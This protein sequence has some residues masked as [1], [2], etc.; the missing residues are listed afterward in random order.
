MGGYHYGA[1]GNGVLRKYLYSDIFQLA[2]GVL[3]IIS[4]RDIPKRMEGNENE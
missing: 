4:D 2:S 1:Y 3:S